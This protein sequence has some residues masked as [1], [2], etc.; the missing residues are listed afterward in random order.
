MP[1]PKHVNGRSMFMTN[2][3]TR[4]LV[5]VSVIALSCVTAAFAVAGPLKGKTYQ[6]VGPSKGVDHEG[7]HVKTHAAG[8]IVLRVSGNGRS[9]TV[10][11]S[12]AAPVLYCVTQERIHVQTSK[13][14]R[15]SSSGKF[16]AR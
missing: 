9:V 15:I 3:P 6:G 7:H 11:F 1:S 10:R 8:G 2:R 5:S 4:A 12:S 14:A 16:T 13:A